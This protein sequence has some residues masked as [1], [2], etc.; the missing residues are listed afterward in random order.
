MIFICVTGQ[1]SHPC[2]S[3]AHNQ[4]SWCI[5]TRY[6]CLVCALRERFIYVS[7]EWYHVYTIG[8]RQIGFHSLLSSCERYN[9]ITNTWHLFASLPCGGRCG[10]A[11]IQPA[12]Q[13]QL[14]QFFPFDGEASLWYDPLSD[15][16]HQQPDDI[17]PLLTTQA[18]FNHR[19]TPPPPCN[20]QDEGNNA[21]ENI[22]RLLPKPAFC[23]HFVNRWSDTPRRW[24]EP[25]NNGTTTWSTWHSLFT[26]YHVCV[27]LY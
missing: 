5:N 14:I 25:I 6:M 8:G 16:W 1:P 23:V 20:I 13:P 18:A 3:S 22:S 27:L 26:Q 19:M 21:H 9:P 4:P 7:R 15:L 10:R 12:Y 17:P 2:W 24:C 11:I